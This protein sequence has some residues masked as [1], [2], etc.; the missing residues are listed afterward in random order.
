MENSNI[1]ETNITDYE[2]GNFLFQY[3]FII[4]QVDD[5]NW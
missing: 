3:Q 1:S 5:D 4:K 2:A